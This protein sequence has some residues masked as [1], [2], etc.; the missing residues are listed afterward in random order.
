[1][2]KLDII[3]VNPCFIVRKVEGMICISAV[4]ELEDPALHTPENGY[5]CGDPECPCYREH[6][7]DT[8][9][10]MQEAS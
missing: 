4:V 7:M 8:Y 2:Q 1:M 9:M 6:A 10:Q 5:F 3:T